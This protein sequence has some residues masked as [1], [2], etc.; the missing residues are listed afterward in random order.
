MCT[1]FI[2]WRMCNYYSYF[3]CAFT[4]KL[5]AKCKLNKCF[6]KS[7]VVEYEKREM[8][9]HVVFSFIW[10]GLQLRSSFLRIYSLLQ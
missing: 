9:H 1:I 6:Q 3:A 7:L 5:Q 4:F 8:R 10:G 2:V